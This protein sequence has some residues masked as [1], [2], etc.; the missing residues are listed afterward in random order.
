VKPRILIADDEP[1]LHAAYRDC[2]AVRAVADEDLAAMGSALFGEAYSSVSGPTDGN[3]FAAYRFDYVSQGGDAIER[4]R[5]GLAAGDPYAALF[6]DMRMP[7][8]IDGLETARQVRVLDPKINIVVVTGYSDHNPQKIANV[9]GPLDKLYY[10]SKPFRT[11]DVQQLAQSL[12]SKWQLEAEL[13]LANQRLE[14]TNVELQASEARARHIALHDQLTQLPNRICLNEYL[15][16][17]LRSG[18]HRV[19]L[20]YFDLDHFKNVNDSL[21]HA[22]GDELLNQIGQ[23][24]RGAVSDNALVARLGGDEF[25]IALCDTD[26]DQATALANRIV[27]LCTG[28]FEIMGTRAFIGCSAGIAMAGTELLGMTELQRRADL[29]LYAAKQAGRANTKL[30]DASLDDS[31]KL[32]SRIE[33]ALRDALSQGA[34]TLNYQPIVHPDTGQPYGYEALL[35]WSDTELGSVPPSMFVPV[36]EQ[37]GLAQPL[38]EWVIRHAIIEAATWESGV[39]SIN[40]SP[41]HFQTHDLVDFV[42]RIAAERGVPLNRIQFEITE[43][44]LFANPAQ[45][46]EVIIAL[47]QAGIQ[48]ALDDFGTGYSSLVNLRDFEIDCIKIDKSFVDTIGQDRQ[49]SAIIT[50]VTAMARLIGLKVVAEGVESGGQVHALRA[51]GCDLMQGY[52][53]AKAM[54]PEDLP[55][56]QG[57]TDADSGQ[58][59]S[60]VA[61]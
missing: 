54:K 10:L 17:Q 20:L 37:C 45:A 18:S 47:R 34:L 42:S 57:A 61:A 51:M 27:E 41:L 52:Y 33:T 56:C 31:A 39:V 5:A 60:G 44:A 43:T 16:N 59:Q 30:F 3:P 55:Y 11:T 22:A 38:G 6:L 29:A 53:Y 40:I 28:E 19:A 32:R 49:A 8:G 46:A 14:I 12:A 21:G 48:V 26:Q 24:M 13:R 9:A 15:D 50:S 4:I 23:R 25:A 2:F 1:Q 7:P 36:A 35:R 58:V